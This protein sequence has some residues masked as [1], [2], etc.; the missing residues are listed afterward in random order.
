MYKTN[1]NSTN[2]AE[3][4]SFQDEN[5]QEMKNV[6]TFAVSSED[7]PET[8]GHGRYVSPLV[9]TGFKIIFEKEDILRE[10][11]NDLLNPPSP[12]KS[13]QY[14]NVEMTPPN[15]KERKA[16]YDLR[17]KTEDGKEF[18]IEMQNL[19]QQF[20][21]DRIIYY[22][23]KS[24]AP[25]ANKGKSVKDESGQ[26]I[27]WNYK[28]HPVYGI[29][30]INFHL[31]DLKPLVTRTVRFKV[32]ETGELFN[33]KVRIYTIELPCFKGKTESDSKTRIEK[34]VYNLVN[35]EDMTTPLAFQDEMP[36]FKR[37]ATVAEYANMTP[38]EQ[39]RYDY[40]LKKYRDHYAQ[41]EWATTKGLMEGRAKGEAIGLAE[42]LEK[43]RAEGLEKGRAEGAAEERIKIANVMKKNGADTDFIAKCLGMTP[44]EIEA[45]PNE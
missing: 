18:I 35:M 37:L 11:L 29:F 23:S 8:T 6:D 33:D 21:T 13:V 40:E 2:S 4:A 26:L 27:D 38:A 44:E 39:A 15:L 9:D 32:E 34:W 42:G 3:T 43:G 12:I 5:L 7:L 31:G 41:M 17:C 25:Q 19:Q 14:L 22:L 30:F 45:L 16:E 28:L 24:I 1:Q 10:F 36:V 20:F